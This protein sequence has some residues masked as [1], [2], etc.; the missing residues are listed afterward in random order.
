MLSLFSLHP[1]TGLPFLIWSTNSFIRRYVHA[2]LTKK[3]SKNWS[4][5]S[6]GFY[7]CLQAA[8][9][10]APPMRMPPILVPT[11]KSGK[12]P[13][14]VDGMRFRRWLCLTLLLP[15]WFVAK[16][17][18]RCQ[19]KLYRAVHQRRYW[20][21]NCKH[22]AYHYHRFGWQWECEVLLWKRRWWITCTSIS[23][24]RKSIG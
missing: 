1:S 4:I 13:L 5:S 2:S 9:H 14:I 6:Q 8:H 17:M 23:K 18:R 15:R 19:R 7:W 16:T 20:S 22:Q 24:E 3:L 11:P 21:N 12:A 10:Q